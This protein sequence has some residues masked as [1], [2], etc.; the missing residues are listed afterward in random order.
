MV[1]SV[2]TQEALYIKQLCEEIDLKYVIIEP[3][4]IHEDNQGD[5]ALV[6]K[7]V[8]HQRNNILTSYFSLLETN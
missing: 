2:S 6:D 4:I 1:I 8:H 7:P 3:I 5:I